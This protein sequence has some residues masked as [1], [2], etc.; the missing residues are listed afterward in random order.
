MYWFPRYPNT[1]FTKCIT[2]KE[3]FEELEQFGLKNKFRPELANHK[4]KKTL[5]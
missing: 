3:Q 2:V 5:M 1:S 4:D